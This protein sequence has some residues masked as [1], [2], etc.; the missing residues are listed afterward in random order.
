MRG[1]LAVRRVTDSNVKRI[2]ICNS[3][4]DL[5]KLDGNTL[6]ELAYRFGFASLVIIPRTYKHQDRTLERTGRCR[7]V[8][9]DATANEPL[10]IVM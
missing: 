9:P 6:V 4:I 8:P 1:P 10:K 7:C 5:V 3:C 2:I